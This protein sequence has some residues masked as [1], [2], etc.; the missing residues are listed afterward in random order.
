[1]DHFLV[2]LRPDDPLDLG[3]D[4]F[5]IG[6]VRIRVGK[7][8]VAGDR[9]QGQP[10][11]E[12]PDH[13]RQL[14]GVEDDFGLGQVPGDFLREVLGILQVFR[15]GYHPFGFSEHGPEGGFLRVA[16]LPEYPVE[17]GVFHAP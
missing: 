13:H 11:D 14:P 1:M 6:G 9:S 2:D 15:P 17:V 5:N 3:D 12:E 16:I 10:A 4:G 7:L 8:R